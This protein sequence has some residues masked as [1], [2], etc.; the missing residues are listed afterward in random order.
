MDIQKNE[1]SEMMLKN[2]NKF[3]EYSCQLE[4]KREESLIKQSSLMLTAIALTSTLI[5]KSGLIE[6]NFFNWCSA[7]FLV[8]SLLCTL[9]M[10]WRYKYT[11]FPY[12]WDFYN[13]VEKNKEYFQ[14]QFQFDWHFQNCLTIVEKSKKEINDKRVR[15][16]IFSYISLFV[17]IFLYFIS[18]LR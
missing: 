6:F 1:K 18:F 13:Y 5:F 17:S 3:V 9:L 8:I 11:N 7:I 4:E 10:G 12:S 16:L 15:F 2:I 14:N